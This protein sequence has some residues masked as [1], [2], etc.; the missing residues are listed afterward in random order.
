MKRNREDISNELA[1]LEARLAALDAERTAIREQ[2]TAARRHLAAADA[3]TISVP[4]LQPPTNPVPTT[5]L[6]SSNAAAGRPRRA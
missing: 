3:V 5:G 2:V 1:Q 4:A 6:A